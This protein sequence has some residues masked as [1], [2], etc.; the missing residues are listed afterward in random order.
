MQKYTYDNIKI[1]DRPIYRADI[2]VSP[3]Y[4]YQPK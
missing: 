2:W 3:I 4:R 1:K